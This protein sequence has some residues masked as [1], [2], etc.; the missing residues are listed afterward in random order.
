MLK[1]H[2]NEQEEHFKVTPL[3]TCHRCNPIANERKG[4]VV[5][6][7]MMDGC[8]GNFKLFET[9]LPIITTAD[10]C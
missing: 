10:L 9:N 6:D 7:R 2:M 3:M 4:G 8:L 5:F 1:L